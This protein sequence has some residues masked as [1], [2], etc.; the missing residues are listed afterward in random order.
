MI[1][2]D[3]SSTNHERPAGVA[4]AFQRGENGVCAPSS[5]IRAVLKSEPTRA[6]LSDDADGFEEEARPLA[7]DAFAFGVGGADVLAGWASDDDLGE[8]PKVSN[9]SVCRKGANV[10]IDQNAWVVFGIE[11]APPIDRFTGRDRAKACPVHPERPAAGRRAE[12]VQDIQ[13]ITPSP[14]TPR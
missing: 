4:E 7:I 6:D 9:K 13:F 12:E 14:S 5:E 11:R 8:K 3:I 2:P 10:V 1:G